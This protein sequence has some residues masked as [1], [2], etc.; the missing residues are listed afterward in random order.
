MINLYND[1][2]KLHNVKTKAMIYVYKKNLLSASFFTENNSY[3]HKVL[4]Y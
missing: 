1:K 2:K 4:N 3:T